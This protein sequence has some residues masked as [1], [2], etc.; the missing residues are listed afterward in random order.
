M[1]IIFK[2]CNFS[3][4]SR[5]FIYYNKTIRAQRYKNITT[6]TN[7]FL[8]FAKSYLENL[9]SKIPKITKISHS[10]G[11]FHF[12]HNDEKYTAWPSL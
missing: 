10:I 9:E 7:F 6:Y 1:F 5:T 11:I 3:K 12:S 8:Q 4:F 2:F